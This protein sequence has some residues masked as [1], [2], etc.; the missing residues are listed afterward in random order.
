[1]NDITVI[2]YTANRISETFGNHLRRVLLEA[3]GDTPLICVSKK[4]MDFGE[5]IVLDT[6]RSYLNIYRE[7]LIGVKAAKTKY[8]ALAEDDMLYSAEHFKFRPKPGTFAY[9]IGCWRLFTWGEP[10]FS[11]GGERRNNSGLICE[12]EL[13]IK[14]M[15]ERFAKYPDTAPLQ[16]FAE[17]GKYDDKIGVTVYPTE[18][19]YTTP[20]NIMFSHYEGMSINQN[21][22]EEKNYKGLG[23]RKR[24]GQLRATAIPHWGEAD[25]IIKLYARP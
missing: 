3:I 6:P 13:Y 5:N 12:R 10:I 7:A 20:A 21:E 18:T 23:I 17:P 1:M 19:F 2:Y 15:E 24:L 8:I 14:L 25:K 11:W 16:F 4:P 22:E 9:N